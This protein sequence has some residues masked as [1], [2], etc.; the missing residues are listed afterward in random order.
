MSAKEDSKRRKKES[1]KGH[2]ALVAEDASGV[3]GSTSSTQQ[4]FP[5]HNSNPSDKHIRFEASLPFKP[6][7]PNT[8]PPSTVKP[9][10][11]SPTPG[12][13]RTSHQQRNVDNTPAWIK[14][15]KATNGS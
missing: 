11:T 14:Q 4:A 9:S 15:H 13:L 7:P 10:S 5:N 1:E 3:D 12:P 2:A 8:P 6:P